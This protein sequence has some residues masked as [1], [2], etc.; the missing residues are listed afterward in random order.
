MLLSDESTVDQ[1]K[2][3]LWSNPTYSSEQRVDVH[4]HDNS[5]LNVFPASTWAQAQG[6]PCQRALKQIINPLADSQLRS[7]RGSGASVPLA[8]RARAIVDLLSSSNGIDA[9][10]VAASTRAGRSAE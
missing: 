9:G 6:V 7:N 10:I 3:G 4:T 8:E 5:L 1:S 2:G